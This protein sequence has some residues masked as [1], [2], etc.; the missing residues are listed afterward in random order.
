M[1]IC[2]LQLHDDGFG[3]WASGSIWVGE[4]QYGYEVKHFEEGSRFGIGEG[5]ISKLRIIRRYPRRTREVCAYDRGWCVRPDKA[6]TADMA[7]YNALLE[8]YN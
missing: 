1:S 6:N 3:G 2:I 8:R 4:R 7:A 5:R